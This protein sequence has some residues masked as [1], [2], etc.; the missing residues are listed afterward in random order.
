MLEAAYGMN[1][2]AADEHYWYRT[3]RAIVG[4]TLARLDLP[5]PARLLEIG[6]GTGANLPM[7]L[8]HGDVVAMEPH[9]GARRASQARA[10][11]ATHVASLA[12]IPT[13]P[14]GVALLLDVLEHLDDPVA[15]LADVRTRL[16]PGGHLVLTVPA[17]QA[18]YG[19]HDEFSA[20]VR[21]YGRAELRR[22]VEAAGFV[23]FRSEWLFRP[24]LPVAAALRLVEA[25]TPK[26]Q[27]SAR[28]LSLPPRWIGRAAEAVLLA[29]YAV[30]LPVP[31]LSLLAVASR[32]T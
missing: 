7:L 10:P 13:G 4:K 20:H 9:E 18:L 32:P 28:G 25:F 16:A 26:R 24:L 22:H 11:R 8:E 2:A 27:P 23:G 15:S 19:R 21:R 1:D 3:R 30:G 29:D 12:E 17:H 5:K 31:G 6:A 14:Y